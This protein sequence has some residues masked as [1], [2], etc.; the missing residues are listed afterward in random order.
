MIIL[1]FL[2]L[3][4]YTSLW[5]QTFFLHRYSAH[6]MFTM[7]RFWEKFFF[8]LTYVTQ[9][10]SY[11]SPTSYGIMHRLH[12]AHTDT[13]E[14][15]HSPKYT[16]GIIGLSI[17]TWRAYTAIYDGKTQVDQ[18]FLKG[19]PEW[20]SF[21]KIAHGWV[22]R[23][24]WVI[25]YIVM[26]V[27]FAHAWW[28]YLFLP[29]HLLM[30]PIH[31]VIVNWVGHKF[32]AISF[33]V[34]NTSRNIMPIDILMLGEGYHNNHHKFPSRANF[35]IKWYEMDFGYIGVWILRHLGVIQM[36]GK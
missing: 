5:T 9:G 2:I 12:H 17:A 13:E 26:Y 32:G 22:S 19:V 6:Q 21:D 23:L 25:A 34:N 33:K 20:A 15:P 11:L 35:G 36:V 28:V 8:V 27:A 4:W 30:A 10:S 14:D 16:P 31:G 18:K 7:S 24:I 3:H 29:I 1:F